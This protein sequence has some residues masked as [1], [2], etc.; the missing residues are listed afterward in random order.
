[1][2][3]PRK[4]LDVEQIVRFIGKGYTVEWVAD[5]FSVATST[6]YLNYS[7]AIKKGGYSG[8]DACKPSSFIQPWSETT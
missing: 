3:R 8:R 4:E 1:M 2:G 7:E 6:L 5:Y